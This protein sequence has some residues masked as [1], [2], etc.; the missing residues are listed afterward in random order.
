MNSYFV[1]VL[2]IKKDVCEETCY[3]RSL[4]HT[5]IA[6][7]KSKSANSIVNLYMSRYYIIQDK[8]KHMV[9]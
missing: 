3:E 8:S 7:A 2:K 5:F 6:C 4:E 9:D 1:T